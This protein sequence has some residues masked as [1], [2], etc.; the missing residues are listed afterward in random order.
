MIH[1][2]IFRKRKTDKE[3]ELI[4]CNLK[5]ERT[6]KTFFFLIRQFDFPD[7]VIKNPDYQHFRE[8]AEKIRKML[9]RQSLMFYGFTIKHRGKSS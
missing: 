3:N 5:D 4:N 1:F 9:Q 2:V 8:L 6:A 7:K